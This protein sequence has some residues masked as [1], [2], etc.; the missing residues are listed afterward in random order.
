M[1]YPE[2]PTSK[3]MVKKAGKAISEGKAND[4][5][6]AVVDQWRASHGYVINT[7]QIWIK[8]KIQQKGYEVEF[9]QRLKRRNT[10]INKLLRTDEKGNF[11]IRDVSAMHD[12]AGCRLIFEN[13]DELSDF[14]EFLHSQEVMRNVQHQLRY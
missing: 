1:I 3:N 8:R 14:R 13:L 4:D 12:L 5:D 7:F 11:L 6:I 2:P 10:V 9:A